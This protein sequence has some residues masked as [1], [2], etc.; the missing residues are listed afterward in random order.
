MKD[1]YQ[2]SPYNFF[3]W[4][5]KMKNVF[6]TILTTA[7]MIALTSSIHAATSGSLLLQGVIT[8][9]LSIEVT[10]ATIA[11]GL[12][13][14][15]TQIDLSVASVRER[16]NSSSGYKVNVRSLNLGK[17]KRTGATEIIPYTLKYGTSTVDLS[18]AIGQT[19]NNAI[20]SVANVIRDVKISYTGTPEE[21]LVEGV[22]ADTVTFE[23]S[24]I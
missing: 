15:T 19:F 22:Y 13:L 17:L 23:I 8:K 6:K 14:T 9:K 10:P 20:T 11:S 21:N 4:S 3:Q 5:E 1:A 16:S 24:S 7:S 18:T 2:K 12:D